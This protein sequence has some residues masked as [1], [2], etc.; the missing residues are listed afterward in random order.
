[1]PLR[2]DILDRVAPERPIGI[3]DGEP[4]EI[5]IVESPAS[6]EVSV[7][8]VVANI[9]GISRGSNPL[10]LTQNG[11]VE[12]TTEESVRFSLEGFRPKSKV[13]LWLYTR[14]KKKQAY[15]GSFTA[16]SDG[17]LTED[18]QIPG[19]ELAGA[20]D[21]VISGI[22][23]SGKRVSVG[24]PVQV[25]QVAQSNGY[26]RSLLAG[27]LFAI[28]GFFI[29]IVRRRRDEEVALRLGADR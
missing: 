27:L 9:G 2:P 6:L 16:S 10:A 24:V 14:D 17:V 12:V 29:F 7:G 22:N 3:V 23:E 11:E 18:I 21:L 1:L 25:V 5:E 19:G 4:V 26:M 8:G 28:G 15:L 13:D 20:A